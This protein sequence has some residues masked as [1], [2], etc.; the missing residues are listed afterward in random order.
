[1]ER[2]SPHTPFQK[3]LGCYSSRAGGRHGSQKVF[4]KGSGGKPFFR[5]VSP[6]AGDETKA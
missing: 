5:K 6:S 2:V 1:M 4:G 3:L